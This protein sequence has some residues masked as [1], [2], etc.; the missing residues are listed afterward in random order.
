M[1]VF[2][3]APEQFENLCVLART[4]EV[5]GFARC[6]VFD[7]RR[8]VRDRYGK[9]YGQ[10]LRTVSAGAFNKIAW[11]RVEPD[12]L[13]FLR[14]HAGRRVAT[15]PRQ[16]ATSL[17]HFRFRASD[18]LVVGSEGQGLPAAVLAECQAQ[19]TIPQAGVT[20]SL[21]VAVA[22]GIVL[23]EFKRQEALGLLADH[24]AQEETRE[25]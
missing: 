18:L 10:K 16:S 15:V 22:S 11:L 21:N 24:A 20:E 1:E 25:S 17:H 8:I 4:L 13:E 14:R 23:S 6:H 3:Y 9:S 2:V 5:F 12:P 7:P 19:I